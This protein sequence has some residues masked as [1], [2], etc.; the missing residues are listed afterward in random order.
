MFNVWRSIILLLGI[1]FLFVQCDDG[2][3]GVQT[4]DPAN[5]DNPDST[6]GRVLVINEGN[7]NNGNASLG[8]YYPKT[9]TFRSDVFQNKTGRPLGDV[10]QSVTFARNQAFLVINNSGKIEVLD[11]TTLKST[12]V[13]QGLPSPR[14]MQPLSDGRAYVTNFTQS[15]ESEITIINFRTLQITGKIVTGGWTEEPAMAAGLVWVPQV[16][17]GWIL[18]V[19]PRND[20]VTDTLKLRP[21]VKKVVRDADGKLWAM[22]NG[23]INNSVQPALYR[24]NPQNK[25]ITRKLV[26]QSKSP[27]PGNLTLNGR[28]DTLYYS[29]KG[30][31]RLSIDNPDLPVNP[32]VPPKERSFYGLGIAPETGVIYASDAFD[33]V[34]RGQ[35]Y[36]FDPENGRLINEFKA[37]IIPAGFVFP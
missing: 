15:G 19:N 2:S 31:Y 18:V 10:F 35:V 23:G 32:I 8:I 14:Y 25:E 12:G 7:F 6:L 33:F 17:K 24:I 4:Q 22:A 34:R 28:K 27:S 36:R 16:K 1:P 9:D 37:G 21:E 29:R 11:S 13:I 30:I 26:F 3:S 20:I 5:P